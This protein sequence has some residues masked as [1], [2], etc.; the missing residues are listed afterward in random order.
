[1]VRN[2]I[3]KVHSLIVYRI[4]RSPF[5]MQNK[6]NTHFLHG[7][8]VGSWLLNTCMNFL[9]KSAFELN[10]SISRFMCKQPYTY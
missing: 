3:I 7:V 10:S 2:T 4:I 9:L 6:H 1:M 5:H 8:T